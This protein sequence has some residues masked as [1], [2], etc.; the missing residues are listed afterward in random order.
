M[1]ESTILQEHIRTQCD[2]KVINLNKFK[3][4]TP[5]HFKSV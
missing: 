5:Q 1:T 4:N 2:N 3:K